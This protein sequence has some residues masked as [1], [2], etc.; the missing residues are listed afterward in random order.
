MTGDFR[1][2]SSPSITCRSVRQTPHTSTRT[3]TCPAAGSGRDTSPYSK[4]LFSTA[5]G[6]RRKQAFIEASVRF[7]RTPERRPTHVLRTRYTKLTDKERFIPTSPGLRR[8]VLATPCASLNA[9]KVHGIPNSGRKGVNQAASG[10]LS[11][12]PAPTRTTNERY[13]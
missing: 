3:N 7:L 1:G 6:V 5:V 11:A 2:A 8:L 9:S 12:R 4:G 13:F 10:F